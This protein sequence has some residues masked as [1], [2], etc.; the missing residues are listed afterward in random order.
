MIRAGWSGPGLPAIG[1]GFGHPNPCGPRNRTNRPAAWDPKSRPMGI[2]ET[3]LAPIRRPE[4]LVGT[5]WTNRIPPA[6][7]VEL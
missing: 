2:P 5:P 7:S 3:A 6:P 1:P 4:S